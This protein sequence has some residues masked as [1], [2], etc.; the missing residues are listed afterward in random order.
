MYGYAQHAVVVAV[1]LD[2][3]AVPHSLLKVGA[4]TD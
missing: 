2:G 3:S 4:V 1:V